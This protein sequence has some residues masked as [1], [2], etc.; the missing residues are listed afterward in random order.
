M[1]V[2]H[3]HLGQT[4]ALHSIITYNNT[5]RRWFRLRHRFAQLLCT[6]SRYVNT[7]HTFSKQLSVWFVFQLTMGCFHIGAASH[8]SQAW[9]FC[10][11]VLEVV[12]VN[13]NFG[14]LVGLLQGNDLELFDDKHLRK[15]V[16]VN[17]GCT[18]VST[19]NAQLVEEATG[20]RGGVQVDNS[21]KQWVVFVCTSNKA[22]VWTNTVSF[23]PSST[24]LL[25]FSE[26]S[27][28]LTAERN[29]V[30]V[31]LL[32]PSTMPI[33]AG[34]TLPFPSSAV[35]ARMMPQYFDLT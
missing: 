1:F 19:G 12:R 26:P 4:D 6:S 15:D 31:F 20:A 28:D 32:S 3:F 21:P 24:H 18:H 23:L 35:N 34:K 17:R 13:R 33:A 8:S 5:G 11:V 29:H 27:P 25:T 22:E 14:S 30:Q 16:D 10:S 7:D 9:G 2:F